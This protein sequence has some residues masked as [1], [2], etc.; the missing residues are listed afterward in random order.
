M[1]STTHVLALDPVARVCNGCEAAGQARDE[2]PDRRFRW[3]TA[4]R[5][6][7]VQPGLVHFRL[8]AAGVFRL[9]GL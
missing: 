1:D 7:I 5:S 4:L 8:S 3:L 9:L 2:E 6:T